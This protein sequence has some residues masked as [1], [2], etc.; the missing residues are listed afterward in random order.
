MLALLN[1]EG[2]PVESLN[3]SEKGTVFLDKTPFYAESGGQ[4]GDEGILETSHH[5]F[6]VTQTK[7][8]KKLIGHHG[9]LKKGSLKVGDKVFAKVNMDLRQA[10]ALNHT[11]THLLH[12]ALRQELGTHVTQKG[13]LVEP[14][15]LRFDFTHGAPLTKEELRRVENLVNQKIRENIPVE[16]HIMPVEEALKKG[17]MALFGEKYEEEVRVLGIEDFSVE[18]CGGT[19]AHGTGD[20][21]FFK[22]LSES[23][24]S[25]G[26]RRIE[27]LTGQGALEWAQAME[28]SLNS[29]AEQLKVKPDAL[30]QR[31]NE[32]LLKNKNLEK[33][34]TQLSAKQA[35]AQ[36]EALLSRAI[37]IEGVSLICEEVKGDM[38]TLRHISDELRNRLEKGVIVLATVE[39]SK[40]NLMAAVTK[41]LT[42]QIHA[43]HLVNEVA[44]HVGGKGGG[45]P[46]MAQAGGT[47]PEKLSEA[48][49]KGSEWVRKRLQTS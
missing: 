22:I 33:E 16:T 30:V 36:G 40:V 48:L 49:E 2:Q 8:Q 24:I 44:H 42:S 19:H 7:K 39:G 35:F 21:G 34:I 41:N 25:A 28:E 29:M 13:S 47:V 43:G 12:A 4:V 6:V 45:R 38:E 17:A 26:V 18:L 23:G 46:D 27:A 14:L 20:I 37:P 3:A 32:L 1:E 10:T 31:V 5:E 11:A 15:R 9:F